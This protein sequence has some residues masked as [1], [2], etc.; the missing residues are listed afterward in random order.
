MDTGFPHVVHY[1]M[2]R[3]QTTY[4]RLHPIYV[5]DEGH[6]AKRHSSIARAIDTLLT[7]HTVAYNESQTA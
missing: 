5:E 7:G 6:K 4:Y 3:M 2:L 1:A